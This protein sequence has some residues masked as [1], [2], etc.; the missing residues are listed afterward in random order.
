MALKMGALQFSYVKPWYNINQA[1][2]NP[3]LD[4]LQPCKQ[5]PLGGSIGWRKDKPCI[6]VLHV[7]NF[8]MK[9]LVSYIDNRFEHQILLESYPS[10]RKVCVT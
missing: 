5:V 4:K 6:Q 3:N 8:L 2:P 9:E 1:Q 7:Y 10:V